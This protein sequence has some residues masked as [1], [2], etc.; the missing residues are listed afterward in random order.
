MPSDNPFDRQLSRLANGFGAAGGHSAQSGRKCPTY[1]V[2]SAED[3]DIKK[4]ANH[5]NLK[6][7]WKAL[8]AEGGHGAGVDG[9]TFSDFSE[10]EVSGALRKAAREILDRSYA[11]QPTH[12]VKIPKDDG[13]FRELQLQTLVDRTIAKALDMCLKDFW[14][15]RLPRLGQDVHRMYAALNR[16]IR[17]HQAF[18]LAIDDIRDCFPTTPIAPVI[19]LHRQHLPQPDLIW[20]VTQIIQGQDGTGIGLSQG[21]P[22][23][24]I[25]MEL[26]LHHYLDSQMELQTRGLPLLFR[27]ADNITYLCRSE[28][29]GHETLNMTNDILNRFGHSLK[30]QD[31]PPIDIR[32]THDRVLL[33]FIPRWKDG[34]LKLTIPQKSY[35]GLK[36]H[37]LTALRQPLHEQVTER[38]VNAWIRSKGPSLT[39]K[40]AKEVV[41]NVISLCNTCGYRGIRYR[42][43]LQVAKE[44]RQEWERLI[45]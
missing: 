38:V 2:N 13:R 24:P 7:A 37:L 9:L 3:F 26:F 28:H 8:E 23:S 31:G 5:D 22:Y 6:T 27:Y 12:L 4:F 36:Q 40:V 34:Q 35:Q 29:E 41:S 42:A 19:A 11:P 20:L 15:A 30:Q 10:G 17:Q 21:S 43:V 25:A 39:K 45:I 1:T 33:G 16:A 44:S 18:V 32:S 14:R